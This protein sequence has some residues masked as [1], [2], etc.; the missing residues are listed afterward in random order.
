MKKTFTETA[1]RSA[2]VEAPLGSAPLLTGQTM[3]LDE[4]PADHRAQTIE[5]SLERIDLNPAP[6][7]AP[8]SPTPAPAIVP[9]EMSAPVDQATSA[10]AA[11]SPPPQIPIEQPPA[12]EP[13]KATV[14]MISTPIDA[15]LRLRVRELRSV[16]EISEAFV[17]ESALRD[18]FANR[19]LSDVAA[20]L[21]ARGGRLRRNR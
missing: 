3:T 20:D 8:A 10:G 5:S 4:L 17:L 7:P 9:A 11:K 2:A 14:K 19:D 12:P 21:R 1:P 18:F 13:K 15:E 6:A 16:H